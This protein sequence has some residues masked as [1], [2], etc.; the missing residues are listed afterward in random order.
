M[1]DNEKSGTVVLNRPHDWEHWDKS[2]TNQ[3]KTLNLEKEVFHEATLLEQL[4]EETLAIPTLP[5]LEGVARLDDKLKDYFEAI[6]DPRTTVKNWT[7]WIYIFE[8]TLS[9]MEARNLQIM[10]SSEDWFRRLERRL[11][12]E[13]AHANWIDCYRIPYK[14]QINT[15]NL[16]FREVA[17]HFRQHLGSVL[18]KP[19][20]VGAIT[21]RAFTV[22]YAGDSDAFE[23]PKEDAPRGESPVGRKPHRRKGK[24]PARKRKQED[25]GSVS[26]VLAPPAAKSKR[27]N[28]KDGC[29]ACGKRKHDLAN[30]WVAFP[31]IAPEWF[32]PTKVQ[33]E[34][35]EALPGLKEKIKRIRA[36]RE[37]KERAVI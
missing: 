14:D 11:Q 15:G 33:T 5:R 8:S 28:T 13:P 16:N 29:E 19:Q 31:E 32:K 2:F 24:A 7:K 22:G 1:S 37:E 23:L 6:C 18:V 26:K 3:V 27:S 4:A 21:K 12:W 34:I 30:C 35:L 36:N 17:A 9:R 25:R 10:N 20:R